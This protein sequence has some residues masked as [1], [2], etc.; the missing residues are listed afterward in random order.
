MG[1]IHIG[2]FITSSVRKLNR[3]QRRL[4]F[5]GWVVVDMGGAVGMKSKSTTH[6]L[7]YSL[8][9]PPNEP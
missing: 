5:E 1:R 9:Y 8:K 2:S 3:H 6:K 7:A 4:G